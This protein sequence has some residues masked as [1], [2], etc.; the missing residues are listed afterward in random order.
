VVIPYSR[1]ATPAEHA[2][3]FARIAQ[4]FGD[5]LDATCRTPAH[6]FFFPAVPLGQIDTYL[7][8]S[9][10]GALLDPH[11]ATEASPSAPGV[12]SAGPIKRLTEADL[13][14][15]ERSM[16]DRVRGFKDP[17]LSRRDF[18]VCCELITL[19]ATDDETARVLCAAFW[20]DKLRKNRGYVARTVAK[21]RGEAGTPVAEVL[22]EVNDKAARFRQESRQIGEG[23]AD[24]EHPPQFFSLA[25]M[26]ARAVF[27]SDGSLVVLRDD[28]RQ[29]WSL[30]DFQHLT[31]GSIHRTDKKG[32]PFFT[33]TA[34]LRHPKRV[35]VHG[36][37]FFA[38]GR[39]FCQSP[40]DVLAL[41]TW[42]EPP[43]IAPPTDWLQ[44]VRPFLDHVAFLVPEA[45]ELDFLLDWLS[46]IEQRPGVL[47]HVHV[48][49]VTPR[50]GIGR[51]WL[52]GVLARVWAGVVALDVD[53]PALLDGGFNGR[54]SR[55]ILTVVNEIREGG[56]AAAYRYAD[57]MKSL[58]TDSSRHIN[59]KYG[60]EY[61]E[62]NAVRWLMFSN[63]ES[64]L[65]LDRFDRR[66]Y[67]IRNPDQSRDSRYYEK[68]YAMAVD[69][70]FIASVREFLRLRDI[71]S[72]NPGQIAPLTK[73]KLKVIEA[74]MSEADLRM[75]EVVNEHPADCTTAEF[76]CSQLWANAAVEDFAKLRH[77]AARA[78]VVRYPKRV[79][80]R[81]R[82]W[83]VWVLRHSETWLDADVAA[84]AREVQRGID[85]VSERLQNG[86]A[87]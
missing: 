83:N 71:R 21:A 82:Q 12:V 2:S 55:K 36:R 35:T 38:G 47:P 26:L 59:P 39:L 50:Q 57:R 79:F 76:I 22:D 37:T 31:A 86:D 42:R 73:T 33:V 41:N 20:R 29:A 9:R 10:D 72:F 74:G 64:A 78:G 32:R 15:R 60:R 30:S 66:I 1:P 44:R 16:L 34:W 43:R 45:P 63:H 70:L 13:T 49:M 24:D 7:T 27:V 5:S 25:D 54:L 14:D 3:T 23:A 62:F 87:S 53:L 28:P 69:R 51:N 80:F 58:F 18:M 56:G 84:V 77:V 6:L 46:H 68:L 67:A 40:D 52:A 11:P 17:D 48:L 19:G 61:D 75:M 4:Q 65:P 8:V 81:K 85:L